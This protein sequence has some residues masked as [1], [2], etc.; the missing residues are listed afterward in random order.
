VESY[1]L[2]C[3]Q[4]NGTVLQAVQVAVDRGGTKEVNLNECMRRFGR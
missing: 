2:T 4:S 3:E 1:T